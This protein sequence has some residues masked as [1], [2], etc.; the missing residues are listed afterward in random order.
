M[1]T[2]TGAVPFGASKATVELEI[3]MRRDA[4]PS[5]DVPMNGSDRLKRT[6]EAFLV[7]ER[8]PSK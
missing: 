1:V 8:E 7:I 6:E 4:V 5:T 2:G 3:K